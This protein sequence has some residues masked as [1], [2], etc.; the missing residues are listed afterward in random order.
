MLKD[1]LRAAAANTAGNNNYD[2]GSA[3]TATYNCA[4]TAR[5]QLWLYVGG[6]GCLAPLERYL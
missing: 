1:L 4:Q 2:C 3:M 6:K 5:L